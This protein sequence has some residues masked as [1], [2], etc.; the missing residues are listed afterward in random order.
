MNRVV[1]VD[2]SVARV[3]PA[4]RALARCRRSRPSG[5]GKYTWPPPQALRCVPKNS[6][7]R[8]ASSSLDRTGPAS[9]SPNVHTRAAVL[10]HRA[11]VRHSRS[12]SGTTAC[13]LR[14]W[15]WCHDNPPSLT[16][17]AHAASRVVL[18]HQSSSV[19]DI[20]YPRRLSSR[21]SA[22]TPTW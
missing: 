2:R 21:C 7:P 17:P 18:P 10:V 5:S 3:E 11:S 12:R 9:A 13:S 16:L 4:G 20:Q 1:D 22:R 15:P 8:F 14:R 19:E 6:T